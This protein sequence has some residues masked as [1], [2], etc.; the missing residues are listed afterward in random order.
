ML[1][2]L[3]PVHT[4]VRRTC[5]QGQTSGPTVRP[6]GARWILYSTSQQRRVPSGYG[7]P[8]LTQQTRDAGTMLIYCLAGI[9]DDGP[10]L[11]Q[12]WVNV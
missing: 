11:K 10:I 8:H 9:K 12:Q 4:A 1:L 3:P 2:A 6:N 5:C 7:R